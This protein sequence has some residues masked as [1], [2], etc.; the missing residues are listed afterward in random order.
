MIVVDT[1][2]NAYHLIGNNNLVRQD[3]IYWVPIKGRIPTDRSVYKPVRGIWAESG[4]KNLLTKFG[5]IE[6][7]GMIEFEGGTTDIQK[8]FKRVS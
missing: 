8:V 5:N 2:G 1:E 3:E 6:A 4:G 7:K